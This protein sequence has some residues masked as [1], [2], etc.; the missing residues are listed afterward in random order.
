MGKQGKIRRKTTNN[1][2]NS[3]YTR[4]ILWSLKWD[5]D[6]FPT[7]F[8]S[9]L[10]HGTHGK[11]RHAESP[12][13]GSVEFGVSKWL[14]LTQF[15]FFSSLLDY[16]SNYGMGKPTRS[17]KKQYLG[18]KYLLLCVSKLAYHEISRT[19]MPSYGDFLRKAKSIPRYV[20]LLCWWE[21]S[22]F[23]HAALFANVRKVMLANF[24]FKIRPL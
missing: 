11:G 17:T 21:V 9:T 16:K 6:P 15:D 10:R 14:K 13:S 5:A 23:L 1:I 7:L 24:G 4:D 2:V 19:S 20:F 8:K 12:A 22:K 18:L 3:L